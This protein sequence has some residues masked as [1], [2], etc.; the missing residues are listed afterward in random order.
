MEN[1]T[2]ICN[3]HNIFASGQS[4]EHQAVKIHSIDSI[5]PAPYQYNLKWLPLIIIY[6]LDQEFLL[7]KT[8][9]V[10]FRV[11]LIDA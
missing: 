4:M 3:L 11:N 1:Q 5:H 2:L 9:P 6:T 8:L 7:A 10:R